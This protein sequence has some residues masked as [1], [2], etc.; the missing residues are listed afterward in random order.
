MSK[1]KDEEEATKWFYDGKEEDWNTF[2][3][4]MIRYMVKQYDEFGE[5]LWLGTVPDFEGMN[6]QEYGQYCTEVWRAI[7]CKDSTK[8]SKLWRPESGFWTNGNVSGSSVS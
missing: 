1:E 8:A 2:D 3:R 6:L 7:D 5:K 4:R